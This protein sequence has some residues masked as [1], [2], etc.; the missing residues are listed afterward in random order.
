M[1]SETE[2][3][4]GPG[5][6]GLYVRIAE[7][8]IDPRQLA[9]FTAEAKEVGQMSVSDEPGCLVLYAVHDKESPGRIRVFEIYRDADA[10]KKHLQTPHFQKFRAA[11]DAMVES[12][13]L[14]DAVPISLASKAM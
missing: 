1:T 9:V 2:T 5:M 4:H 13:R 12:R 6:Q 10:Y 14:I 3:A 7:L 11:T 8:E